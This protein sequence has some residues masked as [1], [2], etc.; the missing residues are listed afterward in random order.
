[1]VLP[2]LVIWMAWIWDL[3]V[4]FK[5]RMIISTWTTSLLMLNVI[6]VLC[7]K[8]VLCQW[9]LCI[10]YQTH[11]SKQKILEGTHSQTIVVHFIVPNEMYTCIFC[12]SSVFFE[13]RCGACIFT[14]IGHVSS[15]RHSHFII[16]VGLHNHLSAKG[17]NW[18][19]LNK[20]DQSI[21]T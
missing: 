14:I 19:A 20:M 16:H 7:W 8:F 9:N 12:N 18:K 2:P 3:M 5:A 10:Q 4:N 13:F 17:E 21:N 1:M 15:P 11:A 6:G